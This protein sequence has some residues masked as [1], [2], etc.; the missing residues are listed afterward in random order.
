MAEDDHQSRTELARGEF[1]AANLRGRHDVAGDS[2]NEQVA[3][4]LVENDL[5]GNTRVRTAEDDREWFL[6]I[7][8]V[9]V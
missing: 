2:N 5:R 9:A 4:S 6:A 1:N 7:H 8:E 3:E